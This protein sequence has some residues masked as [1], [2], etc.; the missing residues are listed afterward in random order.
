MKNVS[1]DEQET[2]IRFYRTDEML[3]IY[4]S[5]QTMITKLKKLLVSSDEYKLDYEDKAEDG[6]TLAMQ[7][8]APKELLALRPERLTRQFSDE[9]RK[10]LS[11][12]MKS[13]NAAKKAQK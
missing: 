4:T 12:K 6:H 2:V 5:D 9:Q 3:D 8:L 1:I 11:E 13:I 7:V 10:A